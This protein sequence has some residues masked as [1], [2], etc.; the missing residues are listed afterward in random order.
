MLL[1]RQE[2]KPHV[3]RGIWVA[4]WCSL[5]SWVGIVAFSLNWT[6]LG[7][8]DRELPQVDAGH[9]L[10]GTPKGIRGDEWY[11]GSPISLAFARHYRS[12]SN[13]VADYAGPVGS[14]LLMNQPAAHFTTFFR[15]QLWGFFI[16]EPDRAFSFLY[17]A[18]IVGVG[19]SFFCITLLLCERIRIAAGATAWLLLSGFMQW[20]FSVSLPEIVASGLFVALGAWTLLYTR[21]RLYAFGAAIVLVVSL[22]NLLM[23]CYPPFVVPMV[24]AAVA[25]TLA[26]ALR[27]GVIEGKALWLRL[28]VVCVVVSL[29][30]VV[31]YVVYRDA[32]EVIHLVRN[33]EYP[34][35]RV[36]VAGTV[37]FS[38]YLTNLGDVFFRDG[39]YPP[40]LDNVCEVSGF[41]LVWPFVIPLLA[42]QWWTV[43]VRTRQLAIYAPL[44]VVLVGQFGWMSLPLPQWYGAVSGLSMAPGT[45]AYIG[46]GVLGILVVAMAISGHSQPSRQ[47]VSTRVRIGVLVMLAVICGVAVDR[48]M[49][50]FLSWIKILLVGISGGMIFTG[51]L[52]SWPS[53]FWGAIIAL[54]APNLLVNP[55]ARGVRPILDREL[56]SFAAQ[57]GH[58][59]PNGRWV[60]FGNDL[61]ANLLKAA[62]V[63]VFNGVSYA[64]RFDD[65][66]AF[67][68]EGRYL[69]SYNRYAH[70]RVLPA[71]SADQAATFQ[72]DRF[73]FLVMGVHPCDRAFQTI[74]VRYF[75]FSYPPSVAERWCLKPLVEKPLE[76]GVFVFERATTTQD[77][78]KEGAN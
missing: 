34:G 41:I 37:P 4:L 50:G 66:R 78:P 15:P 5:V 7:M 42:Y 28:G 46:Q 31:L 16:F 22:T 19:F 49:P 25:I 73:D 75:V 59:D 52:F 64:P 77:G 69:N 74:G 58:A 71:S 47:Q 48:S 23:C 68:P 13:S 1:T 9:I 38:R 54:V 8:W 72:V 57:V 6:S 55:T 45:R 3:V 63:R 29:V 2:I 44:I 20:W 11:V 14:E 43:N 12:Q 10:I 17:A 18:K 62:G 39:F 70:I 60:V 67:D 56:V 53:I 27:Y 21:S 51:L 32:A 65:Y 40:S 26:L 35:R 30:G 76:G 33:T 36:S 61:Y 24:H